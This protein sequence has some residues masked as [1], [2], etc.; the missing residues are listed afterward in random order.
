[1][2]LLTKIWHLACL[3]IPTHYYRWHYIHQIGSLSAYCWIQLSC[4][5]FSEFSQFDRILG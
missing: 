2:A 5:D 1:M 4:L 3:P